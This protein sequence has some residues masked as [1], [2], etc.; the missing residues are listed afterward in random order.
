M[1]SVIPHSEV[2]LSVIK[3]WFHAAVWSWLSFTKEIVTGCGKNTWAKSMQ[4]KKSK[5]AARNVIVKILIVS[6]LRILEEE[7]LIR[8]D[9]FPYKEKGMRGG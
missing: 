1:S 7:K 2:Q 6:T 4:E 8:T 3:H 5:N 9:G